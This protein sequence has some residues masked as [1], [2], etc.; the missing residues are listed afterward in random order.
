MLPT[1]QIGPLA[2]PVPGLIILGGLWIALS[3]CERR[4]IQQG[5]SSRIFYNMVLISLGIG[6]LGARLIYVIQYPSA[7]LASPISLISLNPSLFDPFW[8]VLIGLLAGIAYGQRKR[9]HVWSILDILTPGLAVMGVAFNLSHLASGAAFGKPT[10]LPW[11]IYMWGEI[12]HP[13]QVYATIVAGLI[14][15][16]VLRIEK[17]MTALPS[18][19]LFWVFVGMTAAARMFLEAFRGDSTLI[20]E[21]LR[22]DQLIAWSV[23]AISMFGMFKRL[24]LSPEPAESG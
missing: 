16:I 10:Q 14:L 22:Q 3:V 5:M 6:V 23:L 8:G 13:S 2:L 12:R 7:F 1:L 20:F 19:V 15:V 18:G 24:R 9:L 11:G 4:A 21:S 17:S